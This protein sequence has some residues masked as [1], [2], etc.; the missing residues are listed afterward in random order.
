MNEIGNLK[1]GMNKDVL[2][3]GGLLL[4]LFLLMIIVG[5][6]FVGSGALKKVVCENADDDYVWNE[7]TCQASAT[8]TTEVTVDAIT[9]IAAVEAVVLVVLGLLTLVVIVGLFAIVIKAAMG[10]AKSF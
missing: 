8:N 9:Q 7:N 6:T 5:I 3:I 1:T 10:F 2:A 4:T